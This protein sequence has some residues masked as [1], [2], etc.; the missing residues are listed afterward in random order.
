M[1]MGTEKRFYSYADDMK[2]VAYV[3]IL[4][5]SHLTNQN[6]QEISGSLVFTLFENCV[7]IYR[8]SMKQGAP[9]FVR[10]V[11]TNL[12][13]R[14]HTD[15]FW[16]NEVPDG[17]VN[18]VY[19]SDALVLYSSSLSHL[20]RELSA[21]FG[22]AVV[23]GVPIGGAIAL[24]DLVHSEWI[25]RPGTGICL[26]GG[27]LTRAVRLEGEK[28]GRGMRVFLDSSVEYLARS[29]SGL[30]DLV[31]CPET[32]GD[33]AQLKWW[34]NAITANERTHCKS[35]SAELEHQFRRWFTEKN[36]KNWFSGMNRAETEKVVSEAVAELR[37]LGR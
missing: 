9:D 32:S 19:L 2:A 8:E 29:I 34:L 27:A 21:I 36:T 35:E 23:F 30:R 10:E 16:Y 20:V 24:G 6:A 25:E 7:L 1:G 11:P 12:N 4:G 31:V 15:G 14:G 37:S 17:A 3:D 18:F 22:A 28:S 33:H 26:Y 5:F 13:A